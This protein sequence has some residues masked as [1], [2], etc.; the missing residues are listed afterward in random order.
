MST[1]TSATVANT[2]SALDRIIADAKLRIGQFLGN[3]SAIQDARDVAASLGASSDVK[4]KDA[5]AVLTQK[6][7]A[8]LNAQDAAEK[9]AQAFL[10]KAATLKANLSTP[11]YSF[12]QTSPT[13]WGIRQGEL[14]ADLLLKVTI[15][16][17]ESAALAARVLAQ[18]NNVK[19]YIRETA[20]VSAA[21]TGTG[22]LPKISAA[23]QGTAGTIV[24]SVAAPLTKLAVPLAIG[25]VAVA[26]VYFLP[27]GRR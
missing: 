12:L 4:I 2:T 20:Q 1:P 16:G 15:L 3:Q 18:N 23:I 17:K 21:A 26:A 13:H 5:S 6:G 9:D 24:S 25:A 7:A 8:L 22:F 10:T 27:R 19:T 14:L 11:L